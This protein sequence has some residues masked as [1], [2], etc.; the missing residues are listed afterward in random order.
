MATGVRKREG[1]YELK[2]DYC[3]E[4]WPLGPEFWTEKAGFRQ[5]RACQTEKRAAYMAS[6]RTDPDVRERDR[7]ASAANRAAKIAADPDYAKRSQREWYRRNAESER[8]K[9]RARYAAEKGGPVRHYG[10]PADL[11]IERERRSKREHMRR[12][13]AA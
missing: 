2:C 12:K 8:A 4:W 3:L 13:R 5:C 10:P 9:R 7:L 1:E 6:R 11:K